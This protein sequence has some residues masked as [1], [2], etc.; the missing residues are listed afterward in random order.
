MPGAAE[1]PS[2]HGSLD[3]EGQDGHAPTSPVHDEEGFDS[4]EYREFIRE[5]RGVRARRAEVGSVT[6]RAAGSRSRGD[7][8]DDDDRPRGGSGGQPPEWDGVSQSFQDWLIKCRLWIATTRAKPK[9]QGPLRLSGAPFHAFK[10][11]AKD[12][13]WLV[14]E[15]GGHALLDAMNLPENFGEDREEDLLASLSKVTYHMKRGKDEPLRT[16]WARWEEALRKVKEHQVVLPDRYLGFLLIQALGLADGEIKSLLTFTR[17]SILPSDVREWA[18]KHEMKLQAKDIGLDKDRKVTSGLKAN[19]MVEEDDDP[20]E[21]YLMEEALNELRPEEDDSITHES[22]I[23]AEGDILE[24]HDVAELLNTMIQKKKT[25]VQSAKIKKAKELARGYG[26]WKKTSSSSGSQRGGNQAPFRGKL[27]PGT[28]NMSLRDLK[29]QTQCSGCLQVGHWHRDPECPK[30]QNKGKTGSNEAHYV[31]KIDESTEEAIFCGLL[32]PEQHDEPNLSPGQD[33]RGQDRLLS[34]AATEPVK[35]VAIGVATSNFETDKPASDVVAYMCDRSFTKGI[36]VDRGDSVSG[37]YCDCMIREVFWGE[38][39]DTCGNPKHNEDLCGTIDTG[40]Q[41]MAVGMAT[42]Q[43]LQNAMPNKMQIGTLQQEY[44]FKSVHGKSSTT[45][46]ATV[47]SSL[48]KK[49]SILKPAIFTGEHSENAPFLISLPF[50]MECRTV[51]HLD[52]SRGLRAYFKRFGFSVDLHIGP[53]GA[54]RIPLTQFTD[55]QVKILNQIHNRLKHKH[56]EFEILRTAAICTASESSVPRD[57]STDHA[58]HGCE[59]CQAQPNRAAGVGNSGESVAKD[60]PEDPVHDPE[61]DQHDDRTTSRRR[62]S[63]WEGAEHCGAGGEPAIQCVAASN[64]IEGNT[65]RMSIGDK[66]PDGEPA[67]IPEDGTIRGSQFIGSRLGALPGH[68]PDQTRSTS[69]QPRIPVHAVDVPKGQSQLPEDVMEMPRAPGSTMRD[70]SLVHG[71]ALLE[72]SQHYTIDDGKVQQSLY[73]TIIDERNNQGSGTEGCVPTA[74]GGRDPDHLQ[75]GHVSPCGSEEQGGHQRLCH[76]SEM[77]GMREADRE[78]QEDPRRDRGGSSQ[79]GRR[80]EEEVRSSVQ[81]QDTG[82]ADRDRASGVRGFQEVP[83]VATATASRSAHQRG[84]GRGPL[85]LADE[86][87]LDCNPQVSKGVKRVCGQARAALKRAEDGFRELMTLLSTEPQKVEEAGISQ[88]RKEAFGN[89]DGGKPVANKK[90]L[91]KF[92][93]L[94]NV[95]VKQ[96]KLIAELFNPERFKREARKQGLMPGQA[97]DLVLGHD[98]LKKE[99]RD[100]VRRYV[101]E[102]KP[103]LLVISPPCTLFSALQNLL[104]YHDK[105]EAQKRE[106]ATKLMQAKMLLRFGVEM[107]KEVSGYGG[108]FVFEHPL[109]S[110]AWQEPELQRLMNNESVYLVKND[111]CMFGL[112]SSAGRLHRKPTGWCTSSRSIAEA[113]DVR[114]D[115]S[116]DH[117]VIIGRSGSVNKS[118]MAQQY[119]ARLV[120]AIIKGYKKEIQQELLYVRFMK[121][122]DL[123]ADL[124]QVHHLCQEAYNVNEIYSEVEDEHQLIYAIE[125]DEPG[126]EQIVEPENREDEEAEGERYRYLPRERPFSVRALVKRAHEGLGHPG[127]D[128]L[129]RILRHAGASKEA[130]EE[131][132]K[133]KC[134]TCERHQKLAAPRAAAPPRTWQVNQVVGVDTIWLPTW[135]GK[136]RMAM[137]IVCWAS[138]FQMIIPLDQH[139]AVAARRAYL[140]W[141]RLMGP[142]E[143]V[144]VDLGKEFEGAFELG[145]EIDSTYYD[146]GALEMPTQRSITER[147]GKSFKEVFSRALEQYSCDSEDEWKNLVDITMMTCN[148]LINKSGYSPIQR[149]LGYTPRIPGGIISGGETNLSILGR[150]SGGDLQMQKSHEMRLAAARAFHEADS[151]QALRNALHAGHRPRLEFEPGQMVYFWRK[152][153]ERALKNNPSF[154]RGPARVIL[155]ALPSTVWISYRRTIVKAAPEHLRHANEEE[156]LAMSQWI[157]DITKTREELEQEPKRGYLDLTKEEFP[158]EDEPKKITVAQEDG[159][160]RYRLR[161]KTDSAE[162]IRRDIQDEWKYIP[163]SG[164][165]TRMHHQPR[166]TKFIPNESPFDCPVPLNRIKP[167]RR[168][169]MTS[170]RT[171]STKVEDDEWGPDDDPTPGEEWTGQTVFKVMEEI[172]MEQ[173]RQVRPRIEI[174]AIEPTPTTEPTTTIQVPTPGT[175]PEPPEEPMQETSTPRGEPTVRTREDEPPEEEADEDRPSKRLRVEFLEVYMASL[176]KAMINKMKKEITYKQL[177]GT[178]K[179]RSDAAIRK[180]IKNNIESGAYMILSREESERIRREK[181]DKVMQSRY[182]FTEKPIEDDEV[183]KAPQDGVLLQEG[184]DSSKKA[185]AR[186][187]MKGFSEENSEYLEVTTPQVGKETVM[188][189]L[190]LLASRRWIPGYLDFT[191]AFHSGDELQREL[192]AEQPHEGIPGHHPRQLLKLKKC[193]YG[194]LDGPFQWFSHLQ[195]ILTKDLGYEASVVDPCLFLLYNQG[196]ELQGV[197]SVATDD[198]LH[199]GTEA[200]WKQMEQLNQRYR[201]GKFSKGDGRFVGKEI[202]CQAD[203]S[204]MIHQPLYVKEK[205]KE[206]P[207]SRERKSQ[208]FSLCTSSEIT[209]LRG[210]LGSLAWLSKETRPDLAGRTA[211]LQQSMPTPYVQDLLEANALAREA[212]KNPDVGIKI[213]PIPLEHLRVGTITDASWGNVKANKE[214]SEDR[215]YWREDA[216]SWTRVHVQER[217]LLFHPGSVPG[218]PDLYQIETSRTT[219]TRT[220]EPGDIIQDDWNQKDSQRSLDHT[221]KGETKFIK[222]NAPGGKKTAIHERFLQNQRLASQGGYITFFYDARME[223]EEKSFPISIICWKSYKVKRCTVNT[224]SAECQAM[225]QGVGSL[226]WLRALLEESRGQRL[227]LDRWEEQIGSTPFVAIT[228]SKSLYD[229]VSKCRNTA[230]HIDDKRTAIDV[231]ILKSD[232][233]KTGGQIRWVEGSRMLSDTLTKKMSGSMLRSVLEKGEWSLSEKGFQMQESSVLLLSIQ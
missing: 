133:L 153:A 75:P 159:G 38:C 87:D 46:V 198:L 88:L 126:E 205:V 142:P 151:C 60:R 29:A 49:G 226:H 233:R 32:E 125:E 201:L 34:E 56:D 82:Q 149:V 232:F 67:E 217:R 59:E 156:Q 221:W 71:T 180:E 40:C 76:Q 77:L 210:L 106:F 141:V 102:M 189:T 103:G 66:L 97:F 84:D 63:S 163:G 182:V 96:V 1:V 122:K 131:A 30:N 24:E 147:A 194:L 9:T 215:D 91:N 208:K 33:G 165:I 175:E 98:L 7:E 50:L 172:R 170:T 135:K 139:D 224:L 134:P 6:A 166:S 11:W 19:Y 4:E 45:H 223:T 191:Q 179:I 197:I 78:P 21:L 204:I 53:T 22:D 203:G 181:S 160:C 161:E 121:I 195:R 176:E 150:P 190:Q 105:T 16:F 220:G 218:G 20:E 90:A 138:R 10:H 13:A 120:Q 184:E 207:I 81:L 58:D 86:R 171:K 114:C 3:E 214:E 39:H 14:N 36:E 85:G 61:G 209:Q 15:N 229:T 35:G 173:E 137:N 216:D 26:N 42:L 55:D 109:T 73:N 99:Y 37:S 162:V 62:T 164:S 47:P 148:R 31:E 202:K 186:H 69:V 157:D 110:K 154:W 188:L 213:R 187:V 185:K 129:V 177:A 167:W 127:T 231:T 100:E 119:P 128:R 107:A 116:H 25:F 183:D 54:L 222:K 144:Y 113:L 93:A 43:R 104:K 225:I 228:D 41:R 193:C 152:G 79:A 74:S 146:A 72:G 12:P 118:Q 51:L 140:Q 115:G 192:Y 132:K 196:R 117:E 145:A 17:G 92:A 211:I 65:V 130:I 230:S 70:L 83:E 80:Q 44:K 64:K 89:F 158:I 136:Q 111:Q 18:R 199:G 27:K 57:I 101:R 112:T 168:S 5:R 227:Q 155:T 28:Y 123:I 124:H 68:Q 143:R 169:R 95:D 94:L 178:Q 8:S 48:G 174:P 212:I 23:S 108:H 219:T 52:P 2:S 206:I 200:H